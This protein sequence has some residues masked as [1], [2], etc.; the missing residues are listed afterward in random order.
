MCV[1]RW[2]AGA[3][4]DMHLLCL[5]AFS[6][7]SNVNSELSS[8]FLGTVQPLG[9][10]DELTALKTAFLFFLGGLVDPPPLPRLGVK[11]SVTGFTRPSTSPCAQFGS[12]G[13]E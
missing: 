4:S 11:I 7:Q 8:N 13:L 9:N 1:E 2:R 6:L 5:H 12:L 10:K 3:R